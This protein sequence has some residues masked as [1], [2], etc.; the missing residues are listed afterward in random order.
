VIC[1]HS[2]CIC[3]YYKG[4]LGDSFLLWQIRAFVLVDMFIF[5]CVTVSEC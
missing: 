4:E 1:G 5:L 3:T 2:V